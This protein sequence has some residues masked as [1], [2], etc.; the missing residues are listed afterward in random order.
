MEL[1]NSSNSRDL[2]MLGMNPIESPRLLDAFVPLT[3]EQRVGKSRWE[4]VYV[5]L[6]S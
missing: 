1:L 3:P 6:P 2:F 4:K 5:G